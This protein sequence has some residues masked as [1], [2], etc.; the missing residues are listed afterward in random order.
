[1]LNETLQIEMDTLYQGQTEYFCQNVLVGFDEN[2][3]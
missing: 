1:M 3:C 2:S